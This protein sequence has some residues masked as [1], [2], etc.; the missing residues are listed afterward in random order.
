[1]TQARAFRPEDIRNI[2][3]LG[4]GG[5][6]KTTLAEA[7]LHK[8]HT[9]TR[10][11]SVDDASSVSDFEPE[12]KARHHSTS[13]TVLFAHHEK[14]EINIIDTPGHPEFIGAPLAALSA[15]ETAVI[16]VGATTG[17]ELNTRRL[18]HAAGEAGLAR[19][20]VVN[21]IDLAKASL[22]SRLAELKE[23]FGDRLHCIN[24]PSQGGADVIDCF[25]KDRGQADFGSVEAIHREMVEATVEVD[26]AALEKYLSG[27]AIDLL[28]LRKTFV[29]AMSLGHVVPVLFT[30]AKS[31]VGVEDLLHILVEEAPSPVSGRPRR[32]KKGDALVEL[33][34]DPEQPFLAQVFKVANDPHLGA[35]AM[36]RVLQGK[37]DGSTPFVAGDD[38]KAKKANHVLKVEGRDHPELDAVAEAGDIVAIARAEDVH[39]GQLLR[40]PSIPPGYAAVPVAAP[41]PML[42]LAITAKKKN[43]EVKLGAAVQKILEE[44]PTLKATQD[45]VGHELVLSGIGDVHLAVALERLKNRFHLEVESKRPSIAYKETVLGRAEGHYRHKKQTGG[46]GQFAEVY[47]RIEPL[48]RGEGRVFA[49]EVFGGAIPT[50]FIASVEKGVEDGLNEGALAGFPVQ[51]VKV[52]VYDGK[53][54][55]VDSKDIAFRTAGK[56]AVRDAL[57]KARPALLEPIVSLE[58]TTPEQFLGDVTAD[59][60]HVRARL[61][62]VEPAQAGHSLIHAEAPLAELG[63]YASQLRSLTGGQGNFTIAPAHEDFVPLPLQQKIVASRPKSAG[64]DS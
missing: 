16:V 53:S 34:C 49:S 3:L 51:D 44:D 26:D 36:L 48:K 22:E 61:F 5:S 60:K 27:G 63:N 9:I 13:S 41:V 56:F 35:L 6:G 7:I 40:D 33:A 47:L 57:Q 19:M 24:L 18:F 43:D 50:H 28:E 64:G 29:R 21:K 17:I 8:T 58:I 20:I 2:V 11:G 30:N 42:S 59:L 54:H 1:M 38:G 31:G 32:L 52:V 55:A 39:V 23:A 15:V 4:H 14:R 10:M 12:A 37:M 62:G 46:A 25:D 45:P